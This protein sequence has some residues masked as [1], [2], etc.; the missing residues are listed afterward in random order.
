MSIPRHQNH[1]ETDAFDIPQ[2]ETGW[3]IARSSSRFIIWLCSGVY[4]YALQARECTCLIAVTGQKRFLGALH[5]PV[6]Y[7]LTRHLRSVGVSRSGGSA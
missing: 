3:L 4:M 1:G 5:Q 7:T 6:M 2:R